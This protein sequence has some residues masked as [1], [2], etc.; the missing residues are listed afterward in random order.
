MGR[1]KRNDLLFLWGGD[2][3]IISY[4]ITRLLR[5]E[6]R[7]LGQNLILH[8]NLVEPRWTQKIRYLLYKR[9]FK[10]G[11]FYIT[12]NYE[13]LVDYYSNWFGCSKDCFFLAI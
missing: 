11:K 4:M 3:A 13:P 7:I 2:L 6:C 9:A 12:V 8:K 5:R 10:S 1:S